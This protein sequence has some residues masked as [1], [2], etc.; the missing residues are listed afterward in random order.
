MVENIQETIIK[1][2]R[3]A[4]KFQ[5]VMNAEI[6]EVKRVIDARF[7]YVEFRAISLFLISHKKRHVSV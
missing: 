2:E 1:F 7:W 3:F 4:K 5:L 6:S